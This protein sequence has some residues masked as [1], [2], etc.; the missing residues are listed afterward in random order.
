MWG[1]SEKHRSGGSILLTFLVTTQ[2]WNECQAEQS[3]ERYISH[4]QHGFTSRAAWANYRSGKS[5]TA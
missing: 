2:I 5:G 4:E 3:N 1:R